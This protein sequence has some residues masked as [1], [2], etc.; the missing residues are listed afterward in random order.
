MQATKLV[1]GLG[2]IE[3][4][5]RLRWLKLPTLVYRR[6][7]GDVIEI[8]KDLHKYDIETLRDNNKRMLEIF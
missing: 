8:I 6:M 7:K 3:Y 1:D 5:N 2:N 4:P